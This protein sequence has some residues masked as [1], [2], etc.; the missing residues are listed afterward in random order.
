MIFPI[1]LRFSGVEIDSHLIFELLS[2]TIG[3]RYYLYLKKN[4][5]DPINNSDRLWIFIGACFGG[6]VFS[7]L[8][9]ALEDFPT[10]INPA[11]PIYYY[12]VNKTILGG[13][14]GGL[15]GVEVTKKLLK[16]TSSSGDLMTFPLILG[17]MI[18]RVGCFLAGLKDGTHGTASNLPW[19]I[20]L[21][22]GIR[23]HPT[24]LYEIVFLATIWFL[25]VNLEKRVTLANG[26]KFKI[27]LIGYLF[28]R[29]FSEFIKP[30]YF[31]PFGLTSI[32]IACFF[33]LLYYSKTLVN[34]KSL[35]WAKK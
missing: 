22:D 5:V 17:I 28:Y 1:N 32:Q 12:F 34:P 15:M 16:V 24:S 27:F 21:G 7:R 19:A 2:Y 20:D 25:I 11:T 35:G 14:L 10:F 30:V 4:T 33:G 9:S 18:G 8:L 23:R 31:F 3:F 26:S 29:F 13:L 6:L